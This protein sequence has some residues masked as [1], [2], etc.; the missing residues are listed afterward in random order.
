MDITVVVKGAGDLATGVAHRLHRCG[1]KIVMTEIANPTVVRRTVSFAEAVFSGS[2]RVEGV[3]AKRVSDLTE[4]Q[5]LFKNGEIP[6][7]IDPEAAIIKKL[8]AHV[9]VDAII[10][11][12]NINTKITDAPLVIGLGPG[13]TA[14]VDVHAVIETHRGHNVGRVIIFGSAEPNTSIPGPVNG[15]TTERLLRAPTE[16]VFEPVVEINSTVKTG[17]IIGYVNKKPVL[18][19]I[20]GLLRGLIK[21]GIW[22]KKGLKIGDIDPRCTLEHCHTISDKARAVGGGVLEA[23]L[24]LR[25]GRTNHGR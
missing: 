16:G 15:Y 14:G 18:A 25:R 11:K 10:A 4:A 23:I 3:T 9:V 24:W 8:N 22:V 2:H 6:V 19:E 13:F 12:R 1:F 20:D 5:L 21:G 7:F 17:D